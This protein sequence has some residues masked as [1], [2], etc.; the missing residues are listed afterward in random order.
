MAKTEPLSTSNVAPPKRC[1]ICMVGAY[2]YIY[3]QGNGHA[4]SWISV[5]ALLLLPL[6]QDLS[7]W[8]Q[9]L[10]IGDRSRWTIWRKPRD[11]MQY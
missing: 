1:Q 10:F 9:D 7:L 4:S 8:P 11:I 6:L 5:M 2:I 3:T